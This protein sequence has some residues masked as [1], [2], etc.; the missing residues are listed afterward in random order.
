MLLHEAPE[1]VL[2]RHSVCS[3]L[4]S[5]AREDAIAAPFEHSAI[6]S[7]N[8][9][10]TAVGNRPKVV[11]VHSRSAERQSALRFVSDFLVSIFLVSKCC[12]CQR[13]PLLLA[14]YYIL[15]TIF[16]LRGNVVPC[17]SCRAGKQLGA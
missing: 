3:R 13:Q 14:R 7:W 9:N 11:L 17:V 1:E 6:A 4:H 16:S 15:V 10:A 8:R 2:A 12:K 5:H